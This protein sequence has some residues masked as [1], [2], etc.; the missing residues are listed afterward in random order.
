MQIGVI[1]RN[2][3]Q[4]EPPNVCSYLFY[5]FYCCLFH[6]PTLSMIFRR[7]Q[8]FELVV[9]IIVQ[10]H[11]LRLIRY[12][13]KDIT[14]TRNADIVRNYQRLIQSI[15]TTRLRSFYSFVI[16]TVLSTGEGRYW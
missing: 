13:Q 15:Q 8:G 1:Q 5:F 6:L 4:Y 14:D 3:N 7:F 10:I 16:L 12:R 2:S 11:K 9:Y